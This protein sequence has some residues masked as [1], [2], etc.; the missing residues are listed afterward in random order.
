M[1]KVLIY[2]RKGIKS[3][4]IVWYEMESNGGGVEQ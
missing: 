1:R 4:W 3:W 2:K